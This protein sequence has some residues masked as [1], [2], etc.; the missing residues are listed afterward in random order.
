M[1]ELGFGKTH[2]REAPQSVSA[3]SLDEM[4]QKNAVERLTR[5]EIL[6]LDDPRESMHIKGRTMSVPKA[7]KFLRPDSPRSVLETLLRKLHKELKGTEELPDIFKDEPA[8]EAE[9]TRVLRFALLQLYGVPREE[10]SDLFNYHGVNPDVLFTDE[11]GELRDK[12]E[13]TRL[14]AYVEENRGVRD[15]VS[16]IEKETGLS[17]PDMFEAGKMPPLRAWSGTSTADACSLSTVLGI[18]A[19]AL[20]GASEEESAKKRGL[21]RTAVENILFPRGE[22]IFA[23][24]LRDTLKEKRALMQKEA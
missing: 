24:K 14:S 6:G 13:K 2:A 19:D 21:S 11:Y 22:A 3:P 18:A 4:D 16:V 12:L 17:L 1:T 15:S 5:D 10:I 20:S 7:V 23:E 9:G 8:S